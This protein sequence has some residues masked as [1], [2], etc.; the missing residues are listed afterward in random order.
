VLI[1][2][3]CLPCHLRWPTLATNERFY[4]IEWDHSATA[5]AKVA[6]I[7]TAPF[8]VR[9]LASD[10][11][12]AHVEGGGGGTAVAPAAVLHLRGVPGQVPVVQ[13]LRPITLPEYGLPK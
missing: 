7:Q 1:I 10:A 6:T 12:E 4:C 9:L 2:S 3:A 8:W 11:E 13:T 5:D